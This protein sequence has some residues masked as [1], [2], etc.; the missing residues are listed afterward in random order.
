[1]DP[2]TEPITATDNVRSAVHPAKIAAPE[3]DTDRKRGKPGLYRNGGM[4]PWS[5]A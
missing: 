1:M 5:V 4:V 3:R 2:K